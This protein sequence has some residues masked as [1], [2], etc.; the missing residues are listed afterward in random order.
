MRSAFFICPAK[1]QSAGMKH[2][3]SAV[4]ILKITTV[5]VV[6]SSLLDNGYLG[7][8]LYLE[9]AKGLSLADTSIQVSRFQCI[10]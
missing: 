1:P 2:K 8:V 7:R 5:P 4:L 6:T 9:V 10:V 3:D